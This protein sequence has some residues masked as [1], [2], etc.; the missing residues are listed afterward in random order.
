MLQWCYNYCYK[1]R[2]TNTEE[3]R[4]LKYNKYKWKLRNSITNLVDEMPF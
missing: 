3:K 1:W 4:L 2:D